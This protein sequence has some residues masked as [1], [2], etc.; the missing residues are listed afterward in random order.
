MAI[1]GDDGL[2]GAYRA[3]LTPPRRR[4]RTAA[5]SWQPARP[6]EALGTVR[7]PLGRNRAR[8]PREFRQGHSGRVVQ[9]PDQPIILF[10]VPS[11][12]A[13]GRAGNLLVAALISDQTSAADSV[14]RGNPL[15]VKR[16]FGNEGAVGGVRVRG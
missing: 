12:S 4:A 2:V 15:E 6:P 14:R 3:H 13:S 16:L 7:A 10:E 8:P 11:N 1:V 5:R 9:M